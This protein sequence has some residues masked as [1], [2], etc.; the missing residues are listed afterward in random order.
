M[1]SI[2]CEHD[3]YAPIFAVLHVRLN[4]PHDAKAMD[5]PRGGAEGS[6]RYIEMGMRK[7]R[8]QS[9]VRKQYT[10]SVTIWVPSGVGD[11]KVLCRVPICTGASSHVGVSA[12]VLWCTTYGG[13]SAPVGTGGTRLQR[14]S[15]AHMRVRL[16]V[17]T[18]SFLSGKY[19]ILSWNCRAKRTEMTAVAR[20]IANSKA[21]IE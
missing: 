17:R 12:G 8:P 20:T 16:S 2:D 14:Q 9:E 6:G 1:Q 18:F 4:T 5:P 15:S 21:K 7:E 11:G 13:Q 3:E 19:H 10:P